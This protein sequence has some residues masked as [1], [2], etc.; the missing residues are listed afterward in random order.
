MNPKTVSK[1]KV[2]KIVDE[3]I[4]T[5]LVVGFSHPVGANIKLHTAKLERH[6]SKSFSYIHLTNWQDSMFLDDEHSSL[7][8]V[9][10][11]VVV[12]LQPFQLL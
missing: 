7:N 12:L 1:K 6:I 3:Q 5:C 9:F 8:F 10:V 4:T 2:T 11:I